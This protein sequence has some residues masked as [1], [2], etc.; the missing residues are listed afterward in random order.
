[1]QPT[2][3]DGR[4]G[5]GEGKPGVRAGSQDRRPVR[6]PAAAEGRVPLARLAARLEELEDEQL[7]A[8]IRQLESDPRAGARVLLHRARRRWLRWQQARARWAELA[9]AQDQVA[10]GLQV[11]GVDEVGRGCLAGPVVAAAVILPAGAHLPGLDDSK[12]LTAAAREQLAARIRQQAVAWAVGLATPHEIDAL[13]IWHATRLAMRRA[14]DALAV[15]PQRVLVDGR[16]PGD[17]GYPLD[18]LVDGDARYAAIAAASVV[19]KV[20]RDAWMSRLDRE[21][22]AY[23]FAQHKGYATAAHRRALAR[24]GPCP[25]HRRSFLGA[26]GR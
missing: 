7:P 15:M 8:L 4:W 21:Y 11:A 6:H 9:A 1:M 12:R 2:G 16:R 24:F 22:P 20:Y 13:N 5:D 18:A 10:G 23:G 14:L 17:L 26:A 19:A 25:E 3:R